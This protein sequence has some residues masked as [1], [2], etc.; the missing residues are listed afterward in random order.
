VAEATPPVNPTAMHVGVGDRSATVVIRQDGLAI[1]ALPL[2]GRSIALRPAPFEVVFAGNVRYISYVAARDRTF[3]APLKSAH[4]PVVVFPGLGAA[5][6]KRQLYT[7]TERL[8][9]EPASAR[10][11]AGW[12]QNEGRPHWLAGYLMGRFG[13][14]PVVL[15]TGRAYVEL[16][17]PEGT[18]PV[19]MI[20][21]RAPT[22][23]EEVFLMVFVES[24]IGEG[25]SELAWLEIPLVFS[26]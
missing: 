19:E 23:G 10:L 20:Q 16:H 6:V 2:A 12:T 24:P 9:I 3:L 25:F 18:I 17:Y 15:T 8:A 26:E 1:D 7:V 5:H 11:F 4:A 13:Q 21:G 14:E 22:A